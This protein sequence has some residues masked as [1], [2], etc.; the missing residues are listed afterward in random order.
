MQRFQVLDETAFF[1]HRFNQWTREFES[2]C[3]ACECTVARTKRQW[4]VPLLERQHECPKEH[5]VEVKK[6]A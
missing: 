1:T 4:M 5:S 3:L 2:V 6:A